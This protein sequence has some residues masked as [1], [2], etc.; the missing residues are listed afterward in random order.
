VS[1]LLI[2][3]DDQELLTVLVGFLSQQ[4]HTV[5][6]AINGFSAMDLLAVSEFD[7]IVLDVGLPDINGIELCQELRAR[8]NLTPIIMLT[9]LSSID[10]KEKGLDCGADDYLTKPFSFKELAARINALIRRYSRV[11]SEVLTSGEI[12]LDPKKHQVTKGGHAVH[13]L[14]IDFALLEFFMRN[15][16]QSFSNEAI[17]AKVWPSDSEATDDAVRSAVRRLRVHF[18]DPSGESKSIIENQKRVG[19]RF[20]GRGHCG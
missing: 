2:V 3:D 12:V 20:L 18:D 13:L 6:V 16:Q 5:E 15:P 4:K 1:K 7:A 17:V 14:P 8:K 10:D 9:G 19:Y 11:Y